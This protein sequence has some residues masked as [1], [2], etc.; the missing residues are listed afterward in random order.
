MELLKIVCLDEPDQL[1]EA[2]YIGHTHNAPG[3]YVQVEVL[4]RTKNKKSDETLK[5][6][7]T[8]D[9]TTRIPRHDKTTGLPIM[10][11]NFI[12]VGYEMK[13]IEA[14]IDPET[15]Q[16]IFIQV[17]DQTKPI[18]ENRP[19]QKMIGEYDRLVQLMFKKDLYGPGK[20]GA[21]PVELMVEQAILQRYGNLE[22]PK[23]YE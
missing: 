15:E 23:H 11:D 18:V 19:V 22:S 20:M 5:K 12:T 13:E 1:V 4:L 7:F 10:E 6:V 16:P 21:V 14:G 9:N 3:Q 2:T 8:A 17:P